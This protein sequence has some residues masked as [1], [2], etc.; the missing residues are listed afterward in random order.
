MKPHFCSLL[1][2][3]DL[4]KVENLLVIQP[5]PDDMEIGAGGTIA[6]LVK[7]GT[8]VNCLTVTDGSVGTTDTN[9]S[10]DDLIA[11]R[12]D[13]IKKSASILGI[14]NLIW[15]DFDDGG[16]L[17][18]EIIRSEITC[19][20]RQLKPN[21]LMVCDPWLPYEAHSDH[22]R[23]GLAAA[24]A[25]LLAHMPYFCPADMQDGLQPHSVEMIA[26]Y[27]TAY[28]NTFIDVAKTWDKKMAA[29][30]CHRSQF[31]AEQGEKLKQ[32]LEAKASE[33]A[34]NQN[35][36]LVETFKVLSPGHLHIFEQAWQC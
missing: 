3:P 27:Y 15:L 17:P 35:G 22:I 1:P 10:Q 2:V 9:V 4:L 16:I 25:G 31:S 30:D 33:E 36:A 21:A 20:I 13:E 8:R 29:I 26:F 5:H 7:S 34:S 12:R 24:E 11:R 6:H 19:Y 32:Y 14:E 23:T 18:L 28:P